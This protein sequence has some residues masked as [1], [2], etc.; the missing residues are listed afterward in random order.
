MKN[1]KNFLS[2]VYANLYKRE[3]HD[4]PEA[5]RISMAN[6]IINA[7]HLAQSRLVLNIGSG[8]QS[9]EKQVLTG[10][11]QHV[12]NLLK[13]F[14]FVTLD[15]SYIE[16][17]NLLCRFKN[18]VS[19][20]NADAEY[21]PFPNHT[22]GMGISNLAI[23]FARWSALSELSRVM[24]PGSPLLINFHHPQMIPEDLENANLDEPVKEYWGYLR[25]NRQLFEST[26]QIEYELTAAGFFAIKTEFVCALEGLTKQYWW[27][28]SAFK[29]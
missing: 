13:T 1:P 7:L 27:Q 29:R 14:Q 28:T 15:L 25:K 20:V 18:N 23:D 11:S 26:E 6:S 8:P 10:R 5:S 22:F 9:L 12:T 19:H 2:G 16:T 17:H 4:S 24:I 3:K 21:L